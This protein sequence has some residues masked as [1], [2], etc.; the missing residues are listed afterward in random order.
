MGLLSFTSTERE[1]KYSIC[2]EKRTKWFFCAFRLYQQ[3]RR[4]SPSGTKMLV[5]VISM[6]GPSFMMAVRG[7]YDLISPVLFNIQYDGP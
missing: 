5:E 6:F 1:E 3:T 7:P 4:F 2:L